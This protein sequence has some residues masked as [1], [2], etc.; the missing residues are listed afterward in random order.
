MAP[1]P[2]APENLA[3][4]TPASESEGASLLDAFAAPEEGLPESEPAP[5]PLPEPTTAAGSA[6]EPPPPLV[7]ADERQPAVAVAVLEEEEDEKDSG[8][9]D[10]EGLAQSRLAQFEA[11]ARD[12]KPKKKAVDLEKEWARSAAVQIA[13]KTEVRERA[14]GGTKISCVRARARMRLCVSWR[15]FALA[16]LV[17]ASVHGR[18]LARAHKC[19]ALDK[20]KTQNLDP[21]QD[22]TSDVATR[23]PSAGSS[24]SATAARGGGGASESTLPAM[25]AKGEEKV[26]KE[27]F[28]PISFNVEEAEK[29]AAAAAPAKSSPFGDKVCLKRQWSNEG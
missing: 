6:E 16:L 18:T 25:E 3:Q 5:V 9:P 14:R 7:P 29:P 28:K 23:T 17:G 22:S 20:S 19:K 21:V 24:S 4:I 2:P 26:T 27:S 12:G 1:R 8:A 10:W 13:A 15:I 11:K